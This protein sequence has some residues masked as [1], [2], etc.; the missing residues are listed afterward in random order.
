MWN[1]TCEKTRSARPCQRCCFPES[2][3]LSQ[4]DTMNTFRKNEPELSIQTSR[5]T[6]WLWCTT[7]ETVCILNTYLFI[8][9][10]R[11]DCA[12]PL[13][14]SL[15]EFWYVSIKMCYGCKLKGL[16]VSLPETQ[17]ELREAKGKTKLLT[18]NVSRVQKFVWPEGA[19]MLCFYSIL[20]FTNILICNKVSYLTATRTNC[21]RF[22]TFKKKY[23]S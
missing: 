11:S 19:H 9:E 5:I 4:S 2:L 20:F 16:M 6:N 1:S 17:W 15:C 13:L 21:V 22:R 10:W 18:G 12:A 23:I 14:P 3:S 7:H 8:L